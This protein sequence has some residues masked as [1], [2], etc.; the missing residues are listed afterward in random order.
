MSNDKRQYDHSQ[1]IHQII[2]RWENETEQ[3]RFFRLT[4][5]QLALSIE[6]SK[7]RCADCVYIKD[8]HCTVYNMPISEDYRYVENPCPE[9]YANIPF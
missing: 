7:K 3:E 9:H 6:L 8:G 2:S 1:V 5:L 4:G